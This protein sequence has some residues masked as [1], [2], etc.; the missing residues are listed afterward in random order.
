MS[1]IARSISVVSTQ[2]IVFLVHFGSIP[3]EY[4]RVVIII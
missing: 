2:L 4:T 3:N 1:R